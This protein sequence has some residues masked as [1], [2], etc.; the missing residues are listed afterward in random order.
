MRRGGLFAALPALASLSMPANNA[1]YHAT[2]QSTPSDAQGGA[3]AMGRP[4]GRRFAFSRMGLAGEHGG[5]PLCDFSDWVAT[6][7]SRGV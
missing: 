2:S 4:G 7:T 5:I 1:R 3:R 6:A